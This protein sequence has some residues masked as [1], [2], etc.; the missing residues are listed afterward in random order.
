MRNGL[1]KIDLNETYMKSLE[2]LFYVAVDNGKIFW[3]IKMKNLLD[4]CIYSNFTRNKKYPL[5]LPLNTSSH[6]SNQTL[7][8]NTPASLYHPYK[9]TRKTLSN[10][11]RRSSLPSVFTL[12]T[13]RLITGK[14]SVCSGTYHQKIE[15]LPHAKATT[16][17]KDVFSPPV[18]DTRSTITSTSLLTL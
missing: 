14:H 8:I 12:A 7:T 2:N 10:Q 13:Q 9:N 5:K 15:L 3:I 4:K 18:W 17:K 6:I 16:W 1:L 11:D